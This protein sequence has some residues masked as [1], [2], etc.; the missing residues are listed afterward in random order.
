MKI[1]EQY[2]TGKLGDP[3]KCEDFIFVSNDFIAM[4]DGSTLGV[5]I[6]EQKSGRVIAQAIYDA[7]STIPSAATMEEATKLINAHIRSVFNYASNESVRHAGK[8]GAASAVI[9]SHAH[10]QL[11]CYGD[12]LIRLDDQTDI[13]TSKKIDHIT[14]DVRCAGVRGLLQAGVSEQELIENAADYSFVEPILNIQQASFMNNPDEKELGYPN[15]DGDDRV[16]E[17]V[18]IVDVKAVKKIVFATDGYPVIGKDLADTEKILAETLQQ[19][20]L[21]YRL[22]PQVKGLRMTNGKVAQNYDDRAY[23]SFTYK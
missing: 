1:L 11:W 13:D 4:I 23:I 17:L 19:D 22:Y 15:F 6:N 16:I 20:P 9:F 7:L 12:I 18:R 8:R 2:I 5:D 3:E 21:M 14:A 10:K